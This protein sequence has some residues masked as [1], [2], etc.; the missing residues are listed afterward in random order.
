VRGE[1]WWEEQHAEQEVTAGSTIPTTTRGKTDVLFQARKDRRELCER[2]HARLH[3][4]KHARLHGHTDARTHAPCRRVRSSA[5]NLRV[6]RPRVES[7]VFRNERREHVI[8]SL[9]IHHDGPTPRRHVG[10]PESSVSRC[11]CQVKRSA[12]WSTPPRAALARVRGTAHSVVLTVGVSCAP[13]HFWPVSRRRL[14]RRRLRY[15]EQRRNP[16]LPWR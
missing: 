7:T 16:H 2:T 14:Q 12:R 9:A 8:D 5:N 11:G 6:G 1:S 3:A 10:V 13:P 15:R 4:R